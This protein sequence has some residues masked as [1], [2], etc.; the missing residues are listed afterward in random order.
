MHVDLSQARA[1]RVV[2]DMHAFVCSEENLD[3][4]LLVVLTAAGIR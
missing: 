3:A 4:L 1:A 2:F